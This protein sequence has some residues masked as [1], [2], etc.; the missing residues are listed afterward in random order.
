MALDTSSFPAYVRSL[1]LTSPVNT[2]PGR[3]IPGPPA[4]VVEVGLWLGLGSLML[5]TP[6]LRGLLH[7]LGLSR[8]L[9][10]TVGQ[11]LRTR[12]EWASVLQSLAEPHIAAA[13]QCV[14]RG[15]R[16]T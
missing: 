16:V 13:E 12:A 3:L 8:D 14:A 6:R 1:E 15:E 2:R 10:R 9:F 7:G 11:R 4:D 5:D